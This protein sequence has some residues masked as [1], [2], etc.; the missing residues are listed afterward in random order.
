MLLLMLKLLQT[1]SKV[2][3]SIGS[4]WNAVLVDEW[5][6]S[7]TL[8]YKLI[9]LIVEAIHKNVAA[10]ASKDTQTATFRQESDTVQPSIFVV[11][12]PGACRYTMCITIHTYIFV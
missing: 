11:G 12:D 9:Q 1:N 4:K 2:Y 5:Q 7:N 10:I 3:S 6:D 8:Q